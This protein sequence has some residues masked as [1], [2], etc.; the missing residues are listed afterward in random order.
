MSVLK[1]RDHITNEWKEIPTIMGPQGPAGK[2]GADYVLTEENKQEIAGMVEVSG[3]GEVSVDNKTIIKDTNGAIKT[4]AYIIKGAGEY[5]SVLGLGLMNGS[6][7]GNGATS[8]SG[9]VASGQSSVAIGPNSE[10]SGMYS[11]SVGYYAKAL[12]N[13]Q[14]VIGSHNIT[15]TTSSFILGS[16][17]NSNTKRNA[18]TV[19]ANN[20]V[21]FPGTVVIGEN[22]AEVALKT[23]IPDV[24]GFQTEE[25]VN[26]LIN[27]ALGVIENGSY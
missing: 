15:D 6:A 2:D 8:I 5:S 24:S 3:G 14:V 13:K 20:Q 7:S 16:G 22:K 9:G 18:M 10:S 23:D 11:S 4:S 26:T 17:L 1:F 25:Q 21:H 12:G 19:D 27:Q